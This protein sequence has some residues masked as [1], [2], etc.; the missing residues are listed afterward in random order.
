MFIRTYG[1]LAWPCVTFS[2]T[3][4]VK[5]WLKTFTCA[6]ISEQLVCWTFNG[7]P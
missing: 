2:M 7:K 1:S 3:Y 6:P 4:N 5:L